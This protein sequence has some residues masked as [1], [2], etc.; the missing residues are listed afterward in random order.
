[1]VASLAK[2]GHIKE[3]SL[4]AAIWIMAGRGS[5]EIDND[6]NASLSE[7]AV[8]PSS[9]HAIKESV[10]NVCTRFQAAR[11]RQRTS[12]GQISNAIEIGSFIPPVEELA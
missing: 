9:W 5:V 2:P 7:M 4:R 8:M 6:F 11:N 12:R 10:H 3:A 1:M